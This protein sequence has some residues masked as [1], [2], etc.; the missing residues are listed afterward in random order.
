MENAKKQ[1]QEE[2]EKKA[3][4]A[5]DSKEDPDEKFAKAAEE[6]YKIF[7]QIYRLSLIL[8][9]GQTADGAIDLVPI[10]DVNKISAVL[11][12]LSSS[13]AKRDWEFWPRN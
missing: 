13:V 7:F 2:A 10:E 5:A 12:K 8:K 11:A 9:L 1:T 6:A 4:Q 3:K